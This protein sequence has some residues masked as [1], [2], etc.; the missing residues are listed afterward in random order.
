[1]PA[2]DSS[3][4]PDP[5]P[6]SI[7]SGGGN[8]AAEDASARAVVPPAASDG[9]AAD[10]ARWLRGAALPLLAVLAALITVVVP[11]SFPSGGGPTGLDAWLEARLNGSDGLYRVLVAPSNAYIV[12]PLLL[13]GAVWFASRQLWW[14]AGFVLLA[15]EFAIIVNTLVLKPLWDRPLQHY[16]AY[17]S[18]HTVHLVAVVT[19]IALASESARV[20][21]LVAIVT[22]VVLVAVAVGMIGLGYHHATD[23]IGGAAA[24]VALVAV[25]YIPVRRVDPTMPEP[26]T[27]RSAP[28]R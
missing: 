14:R 19:A 27:R 8:D 15:P 4:A 10:R 21:V 11:L 6:A 26:V 5:M 18:G 24:A 7:P 12:I 28:P 23:V 9:A 17:P 22:P 25:L 13:G 16:L 1:M 2:P 20:R 3:F